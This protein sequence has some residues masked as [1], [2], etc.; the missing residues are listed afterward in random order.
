MKCM[1]IKGNILKKHF[2]GVVPGQVVGGVEPSFCKYARRVKLY[3]KENT[4]V[5]LF[6]DFI[7][8]EEQIIN[9]IF[10]YIGVK[11]FSIRCEVN[12]NKS[13]EL[14]IIKRVSWSWLSLSE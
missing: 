14:N 12:E 8:N 1:R 5:I 10:R 4:K 6:D 2:I 3:S 13:E 9:D 7:K 11:E